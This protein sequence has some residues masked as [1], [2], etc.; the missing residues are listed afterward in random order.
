MV[1]TALP[2]DR[3]PV[4]APAKGRVERLTDREKIRALLVPEGTYAAYALAQLAPSLF[5][6]SEWW[7]ASGPTGAR[8][9][10]SA[11]RAI[12]LHSRGGLGPALLTV[13]DAAALDVLLSLPPGPRPSFAGF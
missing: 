4:G 12:V 8:L 7:S 5:P 6:R 2:S 1:D 10:G 13:G 9:G 11:G 3:E